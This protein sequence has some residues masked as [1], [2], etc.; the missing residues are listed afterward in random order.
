MF[1]KRASTAFESPLATAVAESGLIDRL[2]YRR[3]Q[4]GLA[5]GA[6]VPSCSPA[7]PLTSDAAEQRERFAAALTRA[8][9]EAVESRYPTDTFPEDD[10]EVLVALVTGLDQDDQEAIRGWLR[11]NKRRVID[12][13]HDLERSAGWLAREVMLTAD[14][15]P[16]HRI[17]LLPVE[18]SWLRIDGNTILSSIDLYS[19]AERFLSALSTAI[20]QRPSAA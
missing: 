6:D 3:D 14:P 8:W 16:L 11:D 17:V 20:E 13:P 5:Y 18:G 12:L 4:W 10:P 1:G 15:Q 19:D 2:L 9:D 7:V